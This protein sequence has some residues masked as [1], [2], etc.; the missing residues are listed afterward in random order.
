[1]R[2]LNQPDY[3]MS[4][5]TDINR[6]FEKALAPLGAGQRLLWSPH[7]SFD[8][9]LGGLAADLFEDE[10]NLYLRVDMPGV[11]KDEVELNLEK[12]VLKLKIER[13]DSEEREG[14]SFTREFRMPMPINNEGI[15]AKLEQGVLTI[16]LPKEASAKP[17]RIALE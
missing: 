17:R 11:A 10:D 12:D 14:F 7:F 2:L 9:G 4:P 16:T 13:G 5:M 15:R 3:W 6:W 1:M 8:E